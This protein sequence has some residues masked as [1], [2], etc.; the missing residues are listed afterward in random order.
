M[1]PSPPKPSPAKDQHL[2]PEARRSLSD[3]ALASL[4]A[5]IGRSPYAARA[6]LLNNAEIIVWQSSRRLWVAVAIGLVAA[7]LRLSGMVGGPVWPILSIVPAYIAVVAIITVLVERRHEVSRAMLVALAVADVAA[8]YLT[9][10][11]V[12]SPAFYP[13][14]LLLALLALQFTQMFFSRSSAVTVIV[15]STLGYVALIVSAWERG[16]NVAWVEEGW[17][18]A[19]YLLVA[20]NGI[21]LQASA[22]RRLTV[23]VDLFAAAQR[24]DFS[25]TFVEEPGHEPD[26]ITLLGRAYNHLRSELANL[27]MSDTLT[28]CLNRRGLDHALHQAIRVAVRRG[29][30]IALLAIDLDHFKGINDT[31]GHLAGDS[32]LRELAELLSRSARAG[33]VVARVGGEEFIIL[34]PG[35]DNE[36]AGVVAERVM[37]SVR[38]HAFR[39]PRGRLKVTVSI[40]VAC[41]QVTDVH[42]GS[43]LRARADEAL[44]VA[45]RLGRNRAIMWAPGIRSNATPPWAGSIARR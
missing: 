6:G 19:L 29:G 26:G 31:S 27:V 14:A 10:G 25:R 3:P 44:Y 24:G 21:A 28:G 17:L 2:S 15:A 39:T 34:L 38:D 41:E 36:T 11:V 5:L 37:L 13:R 45:K 40:G 32:V 12:T 23:L 42:V 16:M 43:A 8:I 22:S 9:I 7:V 30:E 20:L 35:A 4:G 33:D 1:V 18:L